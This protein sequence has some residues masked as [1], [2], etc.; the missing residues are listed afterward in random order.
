MKPL[1]IDFAPRTLRLVLYRMPLWVGLLL[2]LMLLLLGGAGLQLMALYSQKNEVQSDLADTQERLALRQGKPRRAQ[3]RAQSELAPEL[4]TAVNAAVRQ[5]NLPW[6]ELL[7]ALEAAARPQVALLELRPEAASRRLLGVAEAKTSDDMIAY[8][9]RLKAQ[10][11]FSA[12][13]LNSHQINEQDRNKPLRFEFVATW[14]E[15]LP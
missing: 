7:D 2:A 14:A 11:V 4:V 8:I 12:V 10:H 6:D 1:D 9:E 5:L 15:V 3:A 13:A